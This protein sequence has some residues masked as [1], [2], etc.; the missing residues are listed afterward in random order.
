METYTH[1]RSYLE[2][3]D[4]NRE[5][6][7]IDAHTPLPCHISWCTLYQQHEAGPEALI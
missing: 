5:K 3:N 7:R 4:I 2:G 1:G 6:A